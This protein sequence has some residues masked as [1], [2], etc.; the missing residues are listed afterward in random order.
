[1]SA[2]KTN[3]SSD[4][5]INKTEK[6]LLN[7]T[8]NGSNNSQAELPSSGYKEKNLEARATKMNKKKCDCCWWFNGKEYQQKGLSKNHPIKIRT[9]REPLLQICI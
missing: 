6:S 7:K 8:A 1:M 2:L 3:S 5:F 4:K 9:S